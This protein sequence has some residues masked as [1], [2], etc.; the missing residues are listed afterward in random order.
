MLKNLL[1][2]A[3]KF[4]ER[5]GVALRVRRAGGDRIAFE[6]KDTGIGIPPDQHEAIFE[7]FRQAD[8]T[9]NRKY[10]GTG[11]GLSISRD[12]ARLLG[13]E[14]TLESA[15]G[16]GSTFTLIAARADPAGVQPRDRPRQGAAAHRRRW[17]PPTASRPRRN[18]KP[19]TAP[20]PATS[21]LILVIEDDPN[22]AQVIE[23]LARELDFQ[24]VV[25]ETAARRGWRWPSS[26]AP[27]PS[28]W[29]WGCPTGRGCRCWT[30]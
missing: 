20:P 8:G 24:T 2:N 17:P 23:G 21:R 5:G 12:L 16:R 9:T 29:T 19:A 26:A 7:A 1:S 3:C 22:F 18:G 30:R 27:A 25:A 15:L 28:C 14:L 6:V 10:G 4:T 13:G 11:L